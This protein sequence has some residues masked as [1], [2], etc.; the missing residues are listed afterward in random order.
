MLLN[1]NA[2]RQKVSGIP[3]EDGHNSLIDNW[4]RVEATVDQMDSAAGELGSV[5]EGLLLRLKP[6]ESRQQAWVDID[7]PPRERLQES[8]G[9]ET[10]I[11]GQA[12]PFNANTNQLG[13]HSSLVSRPCPRFS[14]REANCLQTEGSCFG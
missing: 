1:Q 2:I 7:Y 5:L 6:R 4:A 11:T 3:W 12:D 9:E 8:S 13:E 14:M 10:H